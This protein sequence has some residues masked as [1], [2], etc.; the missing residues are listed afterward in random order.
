[1]KIHFDINVNAYMYK[2]CVINYNI[3]YNNNK[4]FYFIFK[5]IQ[6][7]VFDILT[8]DDSCELYSIYLT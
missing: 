2:R 6:L 5:W 1:M 3:L 4:R 8:D 7:I